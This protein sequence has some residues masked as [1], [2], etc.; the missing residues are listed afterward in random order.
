MTSEPVSSVPGSIK[1]KAALGF[2]AVVAALA[3]APTVLGGAGA[4]MGWGTLG[5]VLVFFG[6]VALYSGWIGYKRSRLLADPPVDVRDLE[7]GPAKIQGEARPVEEAMVSPL[8]NEDAVAYQLGVVEE[9]QAGAFTPVATLTQ[10]PAFAVDDGTGRARVDPIRVGLEV[11]ETNVDVDA[12]EDPPD[13]I[14]D[15]AAAHGLVEDEDAPSGLE[16]RVADHVELDLGPGEDEHVLG[17]PEHPRRYTERVVA[18]GDP[19]HVFGEASPDGDGQADVVIEK[20]P[21]RGMMTVSEEE[22][23]GIDLDR[24]KKGLFGMALGTLLIGYGIV[25]FTINAGAV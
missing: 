25:A 4:P 1:I 8:T 2:A 12:G 11:E 20:E 13:E 18:V 23:T 17:S 7:E 9:R 5:W 6:A 24:L 3:A 14:L 22:P 15:W 10:K 21:T 16:D 19:V